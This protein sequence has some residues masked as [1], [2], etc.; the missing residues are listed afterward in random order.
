MELGDKG[1]M[2]TIRGLW[3]CGHNPVMA[4][5]YQSY[6]NALQ[7]T[8][9]DT[10]EIR[11]KKICLKFARKAESNEKH[12]RWFKIKPKMNTRQG[13]DKYWNPVA[14]TE[15]LKNS[16]ICYITRLLNAHYQR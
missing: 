7:I 11:R 1:M 14:R 15:R 12:K 13:P 3:P 10:L 8:G 16:P 6:Q 5:S 9:L 2:V 4:A